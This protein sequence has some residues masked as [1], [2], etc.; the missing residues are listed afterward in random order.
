[1]NKICQGLVCRQPVGGPLKTPGVT[2]LTA[3]GWRIWSL[4]PGE[5]VLHG[6][7]GVP[8]SESPSRMLCSVD[9]M[10]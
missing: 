1:V 4:A 5:T 2:D 3:T 10:L 7:R 9:S 6:T 8:L